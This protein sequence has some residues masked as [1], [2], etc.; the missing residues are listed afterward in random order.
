[1]R[2]D[3]IK[4]ELMEWLSGLEDD[5]T[6]DYLKVVKDSKTSQK[7]WWYDLTDEQKQGIER[8]L[9]DVDAGRVTPHDFVK[10]KYGL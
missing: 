2:H 1:M 10:K 8:G 3:S 7:D 6:L 5:D 4:I 9:R